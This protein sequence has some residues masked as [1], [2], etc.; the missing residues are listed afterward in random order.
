MVARGNMGSRHIGVPPVPAD[1][2]GPSGKVEPQMAVVLSGDFA[3]RRPDGPK[4]SA[5]CPAS[6]A[7]ET[8]DPPRPPEG[9]S[10]SGEGGP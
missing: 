2:G 10:G 8:P 3:Y 1:L 5:T 6:D 4:S 7:V 9:G